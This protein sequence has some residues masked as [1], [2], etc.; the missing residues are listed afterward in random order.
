MRGGESAD[1][2]AYSFNWLIE[3]RVSQLLDMGYA[4]QARRDDAYTT[5][6]P[7]N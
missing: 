4:V 7:D 5:R 6:Y 2:R 1:C 3:R